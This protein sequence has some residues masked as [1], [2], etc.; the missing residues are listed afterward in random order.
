MRLGMGL[1]NHHPEPYEISRL[2]IVYTIN[3]VLILRVGLRP[4]KCRL[5][6]V[7]VSIPSVWLNMLKIPEYHCNHKVSVSRTQMKP[8]PGLSMFNRE[9]PL[10][11][12]FSPGLCFICVWDTG[13]K[14][15]GVHP[16]IRSCMYY[17]FCVFVC[18]LHKINFNVKY[19]SPGLT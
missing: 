13:P 8:S 6:L 16:T 3:F 11:N 5:G 12:I 2:Y 19:L 7:M 4:S 15:L 18:W 10:E 14:S 1:A 9:S 17:R